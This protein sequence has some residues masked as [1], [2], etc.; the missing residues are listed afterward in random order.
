MDQFDTLLNR[1]GTA[2]REARK[3][4][5]MTQDQLAKATHIHVRQIQ[6][7]ES[8]GTNIR[9]DT[10]YSLCQYLDIPLEAIF[11]PDIPN[12]EAEFLRIHAKLLACSPSDRQIILKT[13]DY[14]ATQF[15]N[16]K[17]D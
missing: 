10:F 6:R 7:I 17:Q 4:L 13:M 15:L 16:R 14:M 9:F 3:R 2:I 11:Y 1:L 8:G 5:Q 12:D